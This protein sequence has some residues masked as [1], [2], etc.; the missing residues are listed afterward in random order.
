MICKNNDNAVSPVIGVVLMVSITII[1]ASVIAAFV[2]GMAG[3]VESPKIVNINVQKTGPTQITLTN[4]GGNDIG[5]LSSV[6]VKIN[7]ED[8]VNASITGVG[9]TV[10]YGSTD[11]VTSGRNHVII[12]GAFAGSNAWQV[13]LDTYI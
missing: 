1:L 12:R 6:Q 5:S 3:T 10:D 2:F 4:Y 13:L 8:Y 7:S 9:D 11:G